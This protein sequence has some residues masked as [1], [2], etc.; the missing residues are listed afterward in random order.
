[1]K[2]Q[3]EAG[4]RLQTA[5]KAARMTQ[6]ELATAANY[7]S[8]NYI[9]MLERGDRRITWDK[10]RTLGKALNV[11]PA[12]IMGETD[13][14]SGTPWKIENGNDIIGTTD[15]M[16]VN[17]IDAIDNDIRF[18]CVYTGVESTKALFDDDCKYDD[19]ERKTVYVF[20]VISFSLS[21]YRCI[22]CDSTGKHE[23]IIESVIVNG[24]KISYGAFV[25]HMVQLFEMIQS[26]V[27]Y[28]KVAPNRETPLDKTIM[29]EIIK[30][31]FDYHQ[32]E[33]IAGSKIK[34]KD[35]LYAEYLRILEKMSTEDD[36]K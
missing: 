12:F 19:L 24:K 18:V 28:I 20:D 3:T 23:A 13:L 29:E 5:R 31:V 30:S 14:M 11:N 27:S 10:A 26:F 21:D 1:M 8:G 6:A 16:L 9:S 4:K 36:V 2:K 7:E 33:A 22:V 17:L 15:F 32:H 35:S 34:E 25:D